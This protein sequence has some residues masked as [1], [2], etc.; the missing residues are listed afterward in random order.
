MR[1]RDRTG[2]PENCSDSNHEAWT[3]EADYLAL[4]NRA[5]VLG[6]LVLAEAA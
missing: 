5:G 1:H 2:G 3:L 6:A 4:G